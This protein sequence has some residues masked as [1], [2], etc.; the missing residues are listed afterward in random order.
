[1]TDEERDELLRELSRDVA[2][3]GTKV[4]ILMECVELLMK[5]AGAKTPDSGS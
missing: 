5:Q 1:M 3:L 2:S 4:S